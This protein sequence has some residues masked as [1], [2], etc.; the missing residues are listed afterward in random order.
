MK[1]NILG[2]QVQQR[3]A[4]LIVSLVILAVIT[5]LGVASMRASNLE[6]RMAA[7]A[8]DRAVAFQA[9]ESALSRVE[10]EVIPQYSISNVLPGCSETECF[11]PDCENGL[12]F[13]GDLDGA[14]YRDDCRLVNEAGQV[15]QPW[16]VS[17]HWNDTGF[18]RTVSVTSSKPNESGGGYEPIDVKYMIEF[19]CFV[20]A[21]ADAIDDGENSRNS[22]VPLYRITVRAEG[23]AQRSSVV[24]QSVYRAAQ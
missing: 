20:P 23:E 8:R 3:G 5:I 10:R 17:D 18:H 24:L 6:L 1:A 4:T 16:K 2:S 15:E 11:K 12:C 14:V 21:S 7:S 13:T 9:A 19:L 22:G